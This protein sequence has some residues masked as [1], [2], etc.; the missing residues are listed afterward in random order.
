MILYLSRED[1]MNY[2]DILK[3]LYF[4]DAYSMIEEMKKDFPVNH[5]FIHI[6]NVINN[7]LYLSDLF[8]LSIH[9]KELLLIAAT[10]HD[11]GYLE[12]R[13]DHAL[14]GSLLAK[15]YLKNKLNDD[16]ISIISNAI[17]NHG[18][19]NLSDYEEKVSLC[20]LL[21]D[22]LDFSKT[23]YRKDNKKDVSLFLS[24]ENIT[25]F[26]TNINYQLNI[27][28]TNK[29]LFN[30]FEEI[31]YFIKLNKV[32]DFLEKVTNK[33]TKINIIEKELD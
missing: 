6:N 29:E 28:T 21:A 12:G 3:D 14:N 19:K 16:D 33:K 15:E 25:L 2:K 7:C 1:N 10:L 4:I 8:N 27:V 11:I 22:K 13:E 26:E 24:I 17:K 30:N 9:Q 23:R 31:H 18:G 20:L 32:F 5:G